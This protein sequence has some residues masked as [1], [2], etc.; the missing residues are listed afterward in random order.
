[1]K[2]QVVHDSDLFEAGGPG[3]V[4]FASD[5]DGDDACLLIKCPGCGEKSALPL[6]DSTDPSRPGWKLV[7]KDPITLNPSVH[8][9]VFSCGWHG[10]LRNG[11]WVK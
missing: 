1:M 3:T 5:K 7:N 2:A 8:H 6:D 11:E 10:Y 9:S 4:M